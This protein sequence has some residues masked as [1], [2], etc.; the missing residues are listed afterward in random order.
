MALVNLRSRLQTRFG[1]DASLVLGP[2]AQ[3]GTEAV[4]ALPWQ[5]AMADAAPGEV[6]ACA[7]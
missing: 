5:P 2:G 3:G 4:L 6:T 7:P 1:A